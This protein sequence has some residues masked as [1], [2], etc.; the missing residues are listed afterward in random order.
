MDHDALIFKV[1]LGLLEPED[2]GTIIFQNDCNYLPTDTV[3]SS[4]TLISN[5]YAPISKTYTD[6]YCKKYGESL[7]Y[8]RFRNKASL[9]A[10]T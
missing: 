8:E 5:S 4:K 6:T 3:T 1:L 10:I 9:D 2:E 7:L